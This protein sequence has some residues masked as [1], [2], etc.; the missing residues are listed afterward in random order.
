MYNYDLFKIDQLIRKARS[1]KVKE[2]KPIGLTHPQEAFGKFLKPPA[3]GVPIK[4]TTPRH[5]DM[6]KLIP[7]IIREKVVR[8]GKVFFRNRTVFVK[9]EELPAHDKKVEIRLPIK[10]FQD[11]YWVYWA[12]KEYAQKVNFTEPAEKNKRNAIW[13]DKKWKLHYF[14]YKKFTEHPQKSILVYN[15]KLEEKVLLLVK[16][17]S[18]QEQ[19][20]E[21]R[22]E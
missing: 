2:E 16:P 3:E 9:I 6:S 14:I 19:E 8:N 10:K 7:K 17:I 13:R 18:K 5:R 12:M 21:K 22:N 20:M 4:G 1:K 11:K 15:N